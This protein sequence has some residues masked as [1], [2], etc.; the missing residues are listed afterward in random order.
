MNTPDLNSPFEEVAI[1]KSHPAVRE[2]DKRLTRPL[3]EKFLAAQWQPGGPSPNP[4]GRPK[5]KIIVEKLHAK[6]QEHCAKKKMSYED[7]VLDVLAKG[8][9]GTVRL[10]PTQ[11]AAIN[12]ILAYTCGKPAMHEEQDS[13]RPMVVFNIDFA[14][15]NR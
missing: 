13:G 2:D 12:L 5:T 7:A 14:N 11:L 15:F 6:L 1:E 3:P 8:A 9:V 4:G 10:T